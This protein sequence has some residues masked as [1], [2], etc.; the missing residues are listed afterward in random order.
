M[1]QGRGVFFAMGQLVFAY[2][3]SSVALY[4]FCLCAAITKGNPIVLPLPNL[5]LLNIVMN[6]LSLLSLLR[7]NP[8]IKDMV[9]I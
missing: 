4:F 5:M 3:S 1:A 7:L 6:Y 9:M 8:Q 2:V